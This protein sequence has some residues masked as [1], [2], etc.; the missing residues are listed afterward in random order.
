MTSVLQEI[1]SFTRLTE[2]VARVLGLNPGSATLQGS[3]KLNL[4]FSRLVRNFFP[5]I[6]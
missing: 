6:N 3:L 2:R 5:G 4:K 1:P